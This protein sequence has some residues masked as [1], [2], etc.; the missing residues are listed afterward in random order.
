MAT[1]GATGIEAERIRLGAWARCPD[2]GRDASLRRIAI[3]QRS[4]PMAGA[5]QRIA[6]L[7]HME[8]AIR[9]RPPDKR[10]ATRREKSR[11]IIE[12]LEPWLRAKLALIS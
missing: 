12:A 11:P 9:G 6:E 4:K 5:L 1:I 10:Q 3:L 2:T 8:A 7:Y